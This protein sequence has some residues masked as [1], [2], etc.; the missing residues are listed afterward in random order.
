MK[1]HTLLDLR[2]SIPSVIVISNG[3]THDVSILDDLTLEPGAI[4]ILDRGYIDFK[5]LYRITQAS[6]F[7][8]TR[9]KKNTQFRRR[10]S[11]QV[12]RTTGI[13]AM[14]STVALFRS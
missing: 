5:R 9:A 14:I 13:I 2:G 8:V 12:D 4:Y 3:K 1:L 6:A 11:R 7:F 10:L